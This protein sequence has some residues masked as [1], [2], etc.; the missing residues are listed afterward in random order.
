[1]IAGQTCLSKSIKA[2]ISNI[3]VYSSTKITIS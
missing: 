1:M 3:L 2:P